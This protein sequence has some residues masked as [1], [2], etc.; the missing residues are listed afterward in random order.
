MARQVEF[1][2][3]STKKLERQNLKS[4]W[5]GSLHRKHGWRWL[6]Q[7]VSVFSHDRMAIVESGISTFFGPFLNCCLQHLYFRMQ[8]STKKLPVHTI[9]SR[10]LVIVGEVP[11]KWLLISKVTTKPSTGPATKNRPSS[12]WNWKPKEGVC[13]MQSGWQRNT[14]SSS[15]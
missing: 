10:L 15:Y 6:S 1:A 5:L 2:F 8:T 3:L 11:D 7:S 9:T 12:S 4:E 14:E 13:L